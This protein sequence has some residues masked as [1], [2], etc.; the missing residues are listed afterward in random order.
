MTATPTIAGEFID[1][2][3]MCTLDELCAACNVD[4]DWI[5]QLVDYAIIEPVGES[6][7]DWQF[8][9]LSVVRVAKA[10]RLG[11]DLDLSPSALA[12]VLDLLDE[13]DHLRSRL[14]ALRSSTDNVAP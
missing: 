6:R 9:A 8:T 10:R 12:L 3:T 7:V 11:H 14:H 4:A 13:V 2:T 5:T 1:T